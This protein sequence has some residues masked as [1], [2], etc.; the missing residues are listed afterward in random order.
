MQAC[1]YWQVIVGFL[2]SEVVKSYK[3]MLSCSEDEIGIVDRWF[4]WLCAHLASLPSPLFK[5][6]VHHKDYLQVPA[7]PKLEKECY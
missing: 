2:I 4:P 6:A 1:L 7:S 3:D 5:Q